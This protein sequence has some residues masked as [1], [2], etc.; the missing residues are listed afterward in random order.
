MNVRAKLTSDDLLRKGAPVALKN[1]DGDMASYHRLWLPI[2][3][4]RERPELAGPESS[5]VVD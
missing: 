4:T 1:R 5:Y 3:S 2:G